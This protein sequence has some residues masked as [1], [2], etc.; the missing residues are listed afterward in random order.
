MNSCETARGVED[1]Y[2][3]LSNRQVIALPT[4]LTDPCQ[5]AMVKLPHPRN[6]SFSEV[7]PYFSKPGR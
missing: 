2:D 1:S 3:P 5:L 7:Y 4:P 6:L